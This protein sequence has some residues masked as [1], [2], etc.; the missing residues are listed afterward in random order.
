MATR[1][2]TYQEKTHL[3]Q[4]EIRKEAPTSNIAPAVPS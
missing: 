4:D 2:I 3:D 1:R